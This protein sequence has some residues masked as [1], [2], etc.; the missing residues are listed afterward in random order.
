[1]AF[2]HCLDKID[3]YLIELNASAEF[4]I[5]PWKLEFPNHSG[6]KKERKEKE[7]GTTQTH[8]KTEVKTFHM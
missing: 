7:K 2:T 4:L 5:S 8:K 3:F 6:G 1:M